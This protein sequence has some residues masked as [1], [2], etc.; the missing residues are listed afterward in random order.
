[1]GEK[2][3]QV[4]QKSEQEKSARQDARWSDFDEH[5]KT[6][7]RCRRSYEFWCDAGMKLKP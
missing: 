1:M 5:R 7:E 6:C 3:F 2:E 4:W